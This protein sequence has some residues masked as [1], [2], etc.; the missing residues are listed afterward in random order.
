LVVAHYYA[1][2][3]VLVKYHVQEQGSL[4]VQQVFQA[5]LSHTISTVSISQIEVWSAFNRRVREQRLT[6]QD[7]GLLVADFAALCASRYN[8]IDAAQLPLPLIR[9][10][11]EHYPLRAYDS[12]QLTAAL[13]VNTSL[14]TAQLSPLTFLSADTTLLSAA[15]AEGLPTNNP[16]LYP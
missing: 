12:I 13:V 8:L 5:P 6:P 15:S 3:S 10:L 1:D 2:S 4:W 14:L 9:Q 7:Y 11:L 16:N